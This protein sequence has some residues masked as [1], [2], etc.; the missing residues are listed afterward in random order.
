MQGHIDL[1]VLESIRRVEPVLHYEHGPAEF[2]LPACFRLPDVVDEL[3]GRS[4]RLC[5][6][7]LA[8]FSREGEG[9]VLLP[10]SRGEQELQPFSPG[11]PAVNRH[12]ELF[13][14]FTATLN[15][16]ELVLNA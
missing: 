15:L 12:L 4:E 7:A 9:L 14:P 5:A 11:E 13:G 16:I 6:W 1:H 3:F 8:P 2:L 10:K